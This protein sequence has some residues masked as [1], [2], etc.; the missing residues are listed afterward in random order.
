MRHLSGMQQE[1]AAVLVAV[2]YGIP[3]R[4]DG[5]V[6]AYATRPVNS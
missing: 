1:D 2:L 4:P 5:V 3:Y 6:G